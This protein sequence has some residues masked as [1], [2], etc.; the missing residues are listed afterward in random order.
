M[1]L[2]KITTAGKALDLFA[3]HFSVENVNNTSSDP[4]KVSVFPSFPLVHR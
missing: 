1:V 3:V 2:R 4:L